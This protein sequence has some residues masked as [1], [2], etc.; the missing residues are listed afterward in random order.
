[1]CLIKVEFR[2]MSKLSKVKKAKI[3]KFEC[4]QQTEHRDPCMLSK[5]DHYQFLLNW[6]CDR[7]R[8]HFSNKQN[9]SFGISLHFMRMDKKI[10]HF[11]YLQFL[12]YCCS[13]I[14]D[15]QLLQ[16]INY[17]F[18]HTFEYIIIINNNDDN[19]YRYL[20]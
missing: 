6:L 19:I 20:I 17:H 8:E 1:M 2:A 12:D 18:V 7:A 5:V 14:C 3:N 10:Y 15:K 13:I 9:R 11:P 4:P 16:M